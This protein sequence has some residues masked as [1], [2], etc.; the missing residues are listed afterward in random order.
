VITQEGAFIKLTL[1]AKG[2]DWSQAWPQLNDTQRV[3]DVLDRAYDIMRQCSGIDVNAQFKVKL[4]IRHDYSITH[5]FEFESNGTTRPM[6]KFKSMNDE[7]G[8]ANWFGAT[9]HELGHDFF[10]HGFFVNDAIK[11]KWG[12]GLCDVV[13]FHLLAELGLTLPA[14]QFFVEIKGKP[15]NVTKINTSCGLGS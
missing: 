2:Y 6:I 14:R 7:I 12:D 5:P 1:Y 10:H 4:E 3:V 9:L 11:A 13:R 8:S 15:Q